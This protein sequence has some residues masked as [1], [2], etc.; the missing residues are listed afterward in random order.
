MIIVVDCD[1]I[2]NNLCEAVLEVYN[3]EWDDNLKIENITQYYMDTFVK[4]PAKKT[5]YHYFYNKDVWKKIK[6][7]PDAKKY[8]NLLREQGHRVLLCTATEPYNVYKK[9][10]WCFREYGF[11]PRKEFFSCP[12]KTLLRA[13]ILIDDY[14][15]NFGGA[16]YHI[17]LNAPWNINAEG[18][19]IPCD[20]WKEI[21]EE[22]QKL[23]ENK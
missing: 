3:E 10:Q 21:Y 15:K 13:D 9:S 19:F 16:K 17:C 2:L 8:I 4:E 23:K 22:I 14:P 1:N 5:F 7:N 18:D 20:N 6:S 12:D 11:D